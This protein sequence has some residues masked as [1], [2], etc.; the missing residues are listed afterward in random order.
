MPSDRGRGGGG[1]VSDPKP[2]TLR[3][4]VL[5]RLANLAPWLLRP[6]LY[7]LRRSL[8]VEFVGDAELRAHWRREEYVVLACWHNRLLVLPLIAEDTP[9]CIMVS[10]HRDG[11]LAARMLSAWGV[12]TVSGSATRGAVGGFLRLVHAFKRGRNMVVLPDGPRG[13]RYVAKPGVIH[14][15][16]AVGAPIFPLA[17]AASRAWRLKSW[18][19]LIVPRPFARVRVVIGAPLS[20]PPEASAE[21][22]RALRDELEARLNALTAAVEAEPGADAEA[23]PVEARG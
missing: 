6:L 19:R 2:L 20:V 4:R 18:D 22:L 9:M 21:E 16:K 23:P 7:L 11:Q 13:P 14:L 12:S 8:R 17:Y 10:Q 1:V 5:A 15:A 3:R